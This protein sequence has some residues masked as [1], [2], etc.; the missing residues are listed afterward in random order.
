[1]PHKIAL[2]TTSQVLEGLERAIQ[3]AH[4]TGE[5]PSIKQLAREFGLNVTTF[6]KHFPDIP[7]EL[8]EWKR[9][10]ALQLVSEYRRG[11]SIRQLCRQTGRSYGSVWRV[12]ADAGIERRPRGG[13]PRKR[14]DA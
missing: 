9:R 12:L 2:P 10:E 6:H 8:N 14:G 11:A 1:M 13:V 4:H 5:R 3:H 7:R